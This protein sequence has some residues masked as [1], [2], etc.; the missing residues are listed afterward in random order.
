MESALKQQELNIL[1]NQFLYKM[2]KCFIDVKNFPKV[3]FTFPDITPLF[4]NEPKLYRALID[5]MTAL[6]FNDPPGAFI[7][8]E[9]FGYLFGAPLAYNLGSRLILA[10]KKGKLPRNKISQKYSMIYDDNKEIELHS[11]IL[12]EIRD[13]VIVDD[14][15]AS[16]GTTLAVIEILNGFDIEIK[17]LLYAVEVI[18]CDKKIYY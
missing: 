5:Q 14:F 4:E 2:K 18:N 6:Y 13:I 3:G 11:D 12:H 1:S 15:L 16:G 17:S 9:S 7:C 10:R 8:I